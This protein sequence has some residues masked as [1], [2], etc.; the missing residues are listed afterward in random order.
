MCSLMANPNWAAEADSVE[1]VCAATDPYVRSLLSRST[2]HPEW[3]AG[4]LRARMHLSAVVAKID[5]AG[6]QQGHEALEGI[7]GLQRLV[8]EAEAATSTAAGVLPPS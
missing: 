3:G 4:L 5:A 7:R 1:A 6:L 8:E 2:D